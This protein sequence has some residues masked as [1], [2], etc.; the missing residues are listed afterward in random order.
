M[1]LPSG[2]ALTKS[3]VSGAEAPAEECLQI[4][5]SRPALPFDDL[6]T[7]EEVF[8]VPTL[9]RKNIIRYVLGPSMIAL[10]VSIGS[11]EWLLGPLALAKYGFLGIGWLIT[12]SAVLQTIYNME[13]ARFT[14]ATGEVP[15]VA[16]MRVPPGMWLWVP[17]TL[18]II[19]LGG[20]GVAGLLPPGRA[21]SPWSPVYLPT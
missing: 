19:Y 14:V 9:D 15:S 17:L 6:P 20:F 12:L 1:A 13:V 2:K 11:G 10:G 7:P 4:G 8:K 18:F 5:I 16:F 3:K 21:C